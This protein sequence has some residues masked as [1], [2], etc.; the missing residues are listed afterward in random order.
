M[1]ATATRSRKTAYSS[2]RQQERQARIL[3]VVREQISSVGY[4]ALNIRELAAACGVALK[5]LYNLYGSK[6]ELV[7]AASAGLL[8]EIQHHANVLT[9]EP[10]IPRYLAYTDAIAGQIVATPR[11]ADAMAQMLFQ[12]GSD[13]RL[14]EVL[15][16]SAVRLSEECLFHAQAEGELTAGIK[17][18]EFA[19]V[20]AG[21]QWGMVLL[22]NKGLVALDM[23]PAVMRYSALQS[24]IPLCVG[25]RRKWL[26]LQLNN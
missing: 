14:V 19:R 6:D 20:L 1:S 21:H 24:L 3:A 4:E 13:H 26:E 11:Y 25:E 16:G 10:G 7:L 5:T 18:E 8:D 22:W 15:L 17:V 23:L 2:P 9:A 12:A